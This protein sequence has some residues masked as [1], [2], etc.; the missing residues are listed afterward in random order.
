MRVSAFQQCLRPR[1]AV[2]ASSPRPCPRVTTRRCVA[3]RC[4]ASSASGVESSQPQAPA[5]LPA[6]TDA[7]R[8][9]MLRL[10]LGAAGVAGGLGLRLTGGALEALAAEGVTTVF[11]AGATGNTGR[12]VVQQLRAAGFAVRAGVRSTA[13][14]LSLGFGADSG[15]SVVE[16]DVTKGKD[17][18]AE[19][20]GGAQV[21]VVATGG[22]PD[23]VDQQ[24]TIDLV[25]AAVSR[26]VSKFVLVS[27]LL[28]NAEAVGQKANPNYIFLQLF[29]GGVLGKKLVAE[30]YLRAS[31]L[32]Y[33][34]IRPG[35][36]SNDPEADVGN[37]V[38][39]GEDSLFALD[40][41]P[42]RRI[43]RDTVAAVAV[44]AVLQPGA[45]KD[46]VVEIVASPSAPKLPVDQWFTGL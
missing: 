24:G 8:R 18:L 2:P 12:R 32:N 28:T 6:S 40:T 29:G 35:G 14:A 9:G 33:T 3:A 13:K 20:L 10:L 22:D 15:I 11:V 45:S 41:D 4:Q 7:G 23:K 31:G 26:G 17:F 38:L 16:A 42:G 43:S 34:I 21:V 19:A 5:R 1:Q 27:S 30:K 36:L 25:D 39:R 46:R 37:V 44:Q